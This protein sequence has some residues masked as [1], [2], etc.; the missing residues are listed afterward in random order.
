MHEDMTSFQ[1]EETP[2]LWLNQDT[3]SV[4]SIQI[5]TDL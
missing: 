3:K 5:L 1:S 4:Q 2:F